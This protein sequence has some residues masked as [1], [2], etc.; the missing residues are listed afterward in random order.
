MHKLDQKDKKILFELSQNSRQTNKQ[1][2][3]KVGLSE[4][5][6][7]YRIKKLI[8]NK[9]INYFYIKTNPALLGYFHYKIFLRTKSMTEEIEKKFINSLKNNTK[10]MWFV[11]TRG[12]YDYVISL[13]AKDIHEFSQFYQE[14]SREYGSYILQRNVSVIEKAAIF[15][16]GY[17]LNKNSIEFKYG[18]KEEIIKLD[19]DDFKLLKLLSLKTRKTATEIAQEMNISADKVI[20]RLK[21]LQKN[22]LLTDFGLSLNLKKLEMKQYLIALKMQNMSPEKYNKLKEIVKK[23]QSLQYF[24]RIIGDREVD[25]E[26]EIKDD[27]QLDKLFKE[28]KSAFVNEL[29]EYEILE[30]TEEHKLN[31]FPF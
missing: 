28:I 21:K 22:G 9:I 4:V 17:L 30:I 16:R 31:Y 27:Q 15:S 1:I 14:L 29:R 23:N 11:S 10:V 8:E 18:G 26:L 20:Y 7:G 3:K 13:L 19:K 24:V 6:V 2:A 12:N 25:L 5:V